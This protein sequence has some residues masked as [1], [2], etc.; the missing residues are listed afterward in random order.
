[1][2]LSSEQLT[3]IQELA[4]LFFRVDEIAVSIDVDMDELEEEIANKR[5][6]AFR[7]YLKGKTDTKLAIRTNVIRMAR[8]GS[9]QA[10]DLAERY[11]QEHDRYDRKN[12]R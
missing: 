12:D 1:M 10:E 9:P 11:I 5:S 2:N 6:A 7:A 4:G 3:K 8:N